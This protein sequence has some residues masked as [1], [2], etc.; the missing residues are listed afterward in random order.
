MLHRRVLGIVSEPSRRRPILVAVAR[1]L[2][3]RAASGT[4]GHVDVRVLAVVLILAG[5]HDQEGRVGLAAI[6]E[7]MPVGHAGRPPPALARPQ[8][9]F[10][11]ILD[12]DQFAFENVHE[13]VLVLVPMPLARPR[14]RGELRLLPIEERVVD[15]RRDADVSAERRKNKRPVRAVRHST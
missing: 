3:E 9:G 6:L 15:S 1:G 11:G 13:L 14:P 12:Q 2:S 10:S 7:V 8:Q 4:E 5:S